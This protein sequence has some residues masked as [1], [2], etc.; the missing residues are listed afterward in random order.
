MNLSDILGTIVYGFLMIF[1]ILYIGKF[2]LANLIIQG[3]TRWI[4]IFNI[5][6]WFVLEMACIN[7]FFNSIRKD[8]VEDNEE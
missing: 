7:G 5:G 3:D 1:F 8:E 6:A 2:G 4:N